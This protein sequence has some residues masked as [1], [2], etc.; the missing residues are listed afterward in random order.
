MSESTAKCKATATLIE[1]VK[2]AIDLLLQPK[3]LKPVSVFLKTVKTFETESRLLLTK[4]T[5][6]IFVFYSVYIAIQTLL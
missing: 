4:N 3:L 5:L 1:T 6:A 2:K